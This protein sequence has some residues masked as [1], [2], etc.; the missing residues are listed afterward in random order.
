M[1]TSAPID[2]QRLHDDLER[3]RD[4]LHQLVAAA[5]ARELCWRGS[6]TRWTNG[7]LLWHLV[8]GFLIVSRL[9]PLVRLFGRFPDASGRA[10]C[11]G[12]RRR[13]RAVPPSPP[14]RTPFYAA[15]R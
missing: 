3:V 6:G 7:Q 15:H 11:R 14:R 12:A 2:R 8:F 13:D 10:L 4:E 9:L 5:T 1:V